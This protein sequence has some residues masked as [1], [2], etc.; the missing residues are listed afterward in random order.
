MP[1]PVLIWLRR[2]LRLQDHPL[3]HQAQALKSPILP[4]FIWAPDEETPW[5]PGLATQ[6]WLHHS[7]NAFSKSLAELGAALILRRGKSL[8]VLLGLAQE[9]GAT[10]VLWSRLW[11]PHLAKRDD[12]IADAL[13]SNGIKT[14]ITD[15]SLLHHPEKVKTGQ[16]RPYQ[17]FTPFWKS[18]SA[19]GD[20]TLPL[21]SP[22][23]LAGYP[24]KVA[25]LKLADLNLLPKVPWDKGFYSVWTPGE[26]G[27]LQRLRNFVRGPMEVYAQERDFPDHQAISHLS[28]HL[29]F[30]EISARQVA[31]MVQQGGKGA[32][33]FKRQLIWRDF[34][35]HLLHHFPHTTKEPLRP[36]FKKFPWRGDRKALDAWQKGQTGYPLVDAGMRELWA[37]GFMHN[38]VRMVAASFLVKHL[39][40]PWQL[41]AK[42]FWDTLVDADLAN[43]TMGW[44]WVAGCGADAAPYFRIFNPVTQ[45]EKFDPDGAYIHQWI[46]ELSQLPKPWIHR[47]F[48]APPLELAAAHVE[49][50]VNYPH[51]IVGHAFARAR[52]LAAYQEMQLSSL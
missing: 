51:P 41:G 38:R 9:V 52:A 29:H 16:G 30:G 10:T 8:E 2:D 3:W 34:A 7:L 13:H 46:P 17:V 15:D 50:G 24:G 45:S 39:L 27:A 42:W 36:A 33:D 26:K 28:P 18:V 40:L 32:G 25:S 21:P 37:T 23:K 14:Y 35:F 44:Q 49:L 11:E 31:Y 6:W 48:D 4:V 12:A 19:A 1:A 22:P 20:V 5:Q 47:P 43:N